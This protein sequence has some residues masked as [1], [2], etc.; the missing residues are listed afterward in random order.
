MRNERLNTQPQCRIAGSKKE[1]FYGRTI[2]Q[3]MTAIS[4]NLDF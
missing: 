2:C 1:V 4:L 3:P